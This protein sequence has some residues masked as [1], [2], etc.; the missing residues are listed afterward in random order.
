MT[1]DVPTQTPPNSET[2]TQSSKGLS[3]WRLWV[4]LLLQTA[5]I[6]A[7]PAHNA[8][9]YL[10]GQR[11]VLQ[12]IPA[13]PYDPLQ[14]P[15][16]TLSYEISRWDR[17]QM[18]PGGK[19]L[20]GQHQNNHHFSFYLV[21]E[22]PILKA[23][24]A[25]M[26]WQPVRVIAE[27]PTDLATHQIALKGQARGQ[28]ITYGIETYYMPEERRDRVNNDIIRVQNRGNN[29]VVEARVDERGNA[30]PVSLWVGDRNYRF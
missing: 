20:F 23:V 8:Y 21:L 16:Q 15:Y 27:H 29:F 19:E 13:D 10:T 12:T 9:T 30:I 7:V 18:L 14:G 1:S 11:I 17:L 6:V 24:T 28:R 26:P 5:L 25:T 4:P 2:S 22:A 3:P